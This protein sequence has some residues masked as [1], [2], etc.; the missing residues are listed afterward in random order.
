MKYTLLALLA[1]Q[2]A[3][4]YEL[5]Q[6]FDELFGAV[7]PPLNAGQIYTTL[8]RLERDE[9]VSDSVV[10]QTD[11]PDKRVYQLT[12]KGRAALEE[13]IIEPVSG[14]SWKDEF[15]TKLVLARTQNIAAPAALIAR[16]RQEYLQTLRHLSQLAA[17]QRHNLVAA[18]M[19]EGAILHLEADLKWLDRCEQ[20][21]T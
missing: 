5:K 11:R 13:W 10:E 18:L 6:A 20:A 9:L 21:L 12:A 16:Q 3:H 19:I 2:P 7:Q 8:G 17:Q 1:T 4:G 14:A 15:F